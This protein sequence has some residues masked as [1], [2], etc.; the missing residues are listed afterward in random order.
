[1]SSIPTPEGMAGFLSR[2]GISKDTAYFM[3]KRPL[4]DRRIIPVPPATVLSV[5]EQFYEFNAPIETVYAAYTKTP[6]S[7]VWPESRILYRAAFFPP[8][9]EP[10]DGKTEWPGLA[11]GMRLFCDLKVFP[12]S[13]LLTIYVGVEV[14]GLEENTCIRYEYLE[15]SVTMGYNEV[16]LSGNGPNSTRVHHRS[17]YRGTSFRD[18]LLMPVMQE[19]LHVGFVDALHGGVQKRVEKAG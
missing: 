15:D 19:Y 9:D 6:P 1:M 10:W 7:Q 2:L 17:E 14:T 5:S 16:R 3:G 12:P 11:M 4:K 8:Y 13:S 18:R